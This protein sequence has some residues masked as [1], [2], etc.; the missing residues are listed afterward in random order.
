MCSFHRISAST[1]CHLSLVV[2]VRL[3]IELYWIRNW[4]DRHASV[5]QHLQTVCGCLPRAI[6]RV[7]SDA[8]ACIDQHMLCQQC[9]KYGHSQEDV[10]CKSQ[11][12]LQIQLHA[13]L[14]LR[15]RFNL[16]SGPDKGRLSI[17]CIIPRSAAEF[18]PALIL[19]W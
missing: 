12:L 13:Y 6:N 1:S 15:G 4:Q 17:Q 18:Q 9:D 7:D 16:P 14:S 19:D 11:F 8:M 5:F 3:K 10:T 2:L